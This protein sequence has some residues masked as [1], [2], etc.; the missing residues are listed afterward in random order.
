[1]AD[2][3]TPVRTVTNPPSLGKFMHRDEQLL[4]RYRQL[5]VPLV[6]HLAAML[7]GLLAAI[8][9][10]Q[11]PGLAAW[12]RPVAWI[13]WIFL[14]VRLVVAASSWPNYQIAVTDKRL[15]VVWGFSTHGVTPFPLPDFGEIGVRQSMRGRLIG[16]GTIIITPAGGTPSTFDYILYPQQLYLEFLDLDRGK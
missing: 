14:A 2:M 5:P 7:G 1:M 15:L 6:M 11:I 4:L 16:Y 12:T 8:A 9:V 3:S 10:S 13:L